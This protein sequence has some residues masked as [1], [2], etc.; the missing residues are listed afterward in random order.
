MR[1]FALALTFIA[2]LLPVAGAAGDRTV[3]VELFTSQGCS[4]CPPADQLLHELSDAEGVLALALHVDYWDYIG[5]KD[6]FA[7]AQFTKRQKY[8][9]HAMGEKM[10]YTPQV[11]VNGQ[12]HTIGSH[13]SD[14]LTLIANHAQGQDTV[15]LSAERSS[16]SVS[17]SATA[18]DGNAGAM[19]V[20]VVQYLPEQSVAI[21][22]GENSGKTIVYS[23]IVRE[24]NNVGQWT[25]RG[26]LSLTAPVSAD[27]P[28]A[29]ILQEKGY[30][31]IVA[32]IDLQ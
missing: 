24:W 16:G 13:A 5:W 20:H 22:R 9:A 26:T 12:D 25:G 11:V 7:S 27:L 6:V 29:V 23:N 28:V 18:R 31:P 30:G 32:A 17:I 19:D 1:R 10:V 8:Y 4:S 14:V 3:V 2:G 15:D 21:T